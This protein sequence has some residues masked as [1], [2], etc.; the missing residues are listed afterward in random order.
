MKKQFIPAFWIISTLYQSLYFNLFCETAFLK[1]NWLE[2]LKCNIASDEID[3]SSI[4]MLM[5][6]S[7]Y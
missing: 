2:N 4:T 6:H 3:K 5:Y 1:E 7:C